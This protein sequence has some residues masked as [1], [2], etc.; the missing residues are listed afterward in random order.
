LGININR[1][2]AIGYG[3]AKPKVPN[4]TDENRKMNRRT[5]FQILKL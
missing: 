3:S 2:E 1:L 4:D 5:E